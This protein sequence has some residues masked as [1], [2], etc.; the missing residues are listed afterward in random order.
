VKKVWENTVAHND[1]YK[2]AKLP[3]HHRDMERIGIHVSKR[4]GAERH[5]IIRVSTVDGRSVSG[6]V[7]GHEKEKTELQ[8][9]YDLRRALG[10]NVDDE[11]SLTVEHLG[12]LGVLHWYLTVRDP[13]IRTSAILA[14]VS[15]GLGAIGLVLGLISIF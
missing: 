15:V 10:A 8:L 2:I 4:D 7:I 13:H 12:W 1:T 9:D 6:S 3:M 14:I 11:L 5:D